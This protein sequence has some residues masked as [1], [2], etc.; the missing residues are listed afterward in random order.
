[1]QVLL[2]GAIID[3]GPQPIRAARAQAEILLNAAG[4]PKQ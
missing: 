2:D 3:Q 4:V 1:V